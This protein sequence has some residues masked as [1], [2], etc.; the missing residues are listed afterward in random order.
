MR[1]SIYRNSCGG[2]NTHIR[3]QEI[4]IRRLRHYFRGAVGQ[5]LLVVVMGTYWRQQ[6]KTGHVGA[7]TQSFKLARHHDHDQLINFDRDNFDLTFFLSGAATYERGSSILGHRHSATQSRLGLSL[8]F[9]TS[10]RTYTA[11]YNILR[12]SLRPDVTSTRREIQCQ[13]RSLSS[14]NRDENPSTATRKVGP[15]DMFCSSNSGK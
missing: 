5:N 6:L 14:T 13:A 12:L 3:E 1:P 2:E 15:I 10:S 4:G 8:D 11:L 9:S 7:L